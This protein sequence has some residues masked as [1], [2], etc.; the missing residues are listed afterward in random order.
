[1]GNCGVKD[2]MLRFPARELIIG[3]TTIPASAEE[4]G[5]TFVEALT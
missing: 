3:A 5:R 1:L 4:P 2:N